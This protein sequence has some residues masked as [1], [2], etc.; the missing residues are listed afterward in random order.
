METAIL[1]KIQKE[2]QET[3]QQLQNNVATLDAIKIQKLGKKY[4]DL[5][6]K[7]MVIDKYFSLQK[8]LTDIQ[9]T[10]TDNEPAELVAL[11]K[12][13]LVNL[14]AKIISTE[15]ELQILLLPKD[16]NDSK[17][18]IIEMRAGAGGDEAALFAAELFRVYAR[19]AQTLRWKIDLISKSENELGGYKE[20]IFGVSGQ[21]AYAQ[22]K[23]ESGV[24]RV[25]R[26]PAT[27]KAGRVHTSTITVA[28]L[29]E[30]YEKDLEISENDLRIDVFRSGGHGG[31]SVNT[32]DSAVRITHLPTN[33]VVT[34]QDE[35]S[36]HKNKAKA[37]G[38]L[39]ARLLAV[40]EEEENKKLGDARRSQ[41]G[42]GDRSE[43]IRTYNFP[44][45]RI[46][47]HRIK[48]S[49]NNIEEK[50]NGNWE[51]IFAAL[52]AA[53]QAKKLEQLNA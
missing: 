6:E 44:Q 43:K 11:A 17:N 3:E 30:A 1:K 4:N 15:K 52:Q 38:V 34:C 23:Y 31:Q 5:K 36:Q 45:D 48:Q 41:I 22:L 25:Q 24:H 7:M 32:T 33:T 13:E 37:L 40:K 49:W 53:D 50:M 26:I 29:P 51:N 8:A 18:C 42:T 16:P 27:E 46:T 47:D 9:K 21:N 19:Y 12:E 28:V 10:I 20:I 39:R 14:Q 2:Y 35:K